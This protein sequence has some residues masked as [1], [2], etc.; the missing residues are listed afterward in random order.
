MTLKLHTKAPMKTLA[1][2]ALAP[3]PV[4]ALAVA[5][6][7]PTPVYREGEVLVRYR[8]GAADAE[9]QAAK[10]RLGM[11]TKRLI[12]QR[13]AERLELVV[14]PRFTTTAAAIAVLRNDPAVERA[15]PNFRRYPRSVI[16][17][18][19]RFG[20]Q[21]GLRNTGQPNFV[22][23]GNPGIPG[24]D[25]NMIEAWDEDGDGTADRTG[26]PSVIIEVAHPDLV[27]NVVMPQNFISC[28]DADDPSP[29]TSQGQH[30]TLVSGCVAGRGD[31]GTGVAGTAWNTSLMPLKFGYDTATHLDAIAYARDNGAKIINASFGGPGF[32]QEERDLIAS[33]A[34]DDVLYV[35]SAGNDDSNTDVAQLNYPSNYEADNIVSVAATSR[36][37]DITSFS[38][39][40][41]LTVDVAA[42]G[43]QIVTTAIGGN[44]SGNPGV[45]GTS[46]S[47]PYT[48]GV[49]AL[50]KAHV[51]PVPG[52]MEMKARLIESGTSVA[53][54]NAKL[55]TVGGRVDADAA[56]DMAARP[57]LVITGVAFDDGGNGVPDP[58]ETLDVT[59]TV[60]NLWQ[61]ATNV[62]ATLA[63]DDA[64]VTIG[65]GMQALG[66]IAA[67]GTGTATFAITVAGGITEH[68]YLS[69]TL[70]LAAD[71]GYAAERSFG[72]ELG[73]LTPG[74]EVVQAFTG[75]IYDDFHA[76]HVDIPDGTNKTL[77]L[78]TRQTG[79]Q[80]I[81]L[82][83]KGDVPPQYSITVG[84]NP[85][86]QDGFFCT[87]G[88]ADFCRDPD[89]LVSAR[90]D[91]TEEV[92]IVDPAAGTY[93]LV[94]VN[95]AQHDTPIDYSVEA[96]LLDGD[97]RPEPFDFVDRV[98]VSGTVESNEIL[99]TGISAA[100]PITI[101][102]GEYR[103]NDGGYTTQPGLVANTDRV[104]LRSQNVGGGTRRVQVT[105]GGVT[106]T[107][108]LNP[109]VAG[110]TPDDETSCGGGGFS[111]GGGLPLSTLALLALGALAR[112]LRAA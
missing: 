75:D 5:P 86:V 68:R 47:S 71:G 60:R 72:A 3:F 44:Y 20:Q 49:A 79:G 30:G 106:E 28:Q 59:F 21:W 69:F 51:T 83:A 11:S 34:A 4:A 65:S 111:G 38:Q 35:A 101:A 67:L 104:R 58:G 31:N 103:V 102:G 74:S 107:W 110:I 91:G 112:R 36:E 6:D 56:L 80:D 45:S 78:R 2:A 85:E 87:S 22:F 27:A 62:T 15:E 55:K 32:S 50:L 63:V 66:A 64:D 94:V 77:F 9:V 92:S 23:G 95:F 18:D 7:R 81:D 97:L 12:R 109:S 25:L 100:T 13:R 73:T 90:L 24:A 96:E 29:V 57:A 37:D 17:N 10:A 99:V 98:A 39:Y 43:L 93:H 108:F 14:L 84:I 46:F 89:T 33:L 19:P 16:P 70:Q 76:W 105:I 8:A 53:G 40:G 88:T 82:L 61:A 26:D 48:A 41:N 52:F 54:A 1:A 42:P